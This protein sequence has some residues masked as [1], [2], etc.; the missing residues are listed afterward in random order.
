MPDR[1]SAVSALPA[2]PKP[3]RC[4]D[5]AWRD[6]LRSASCWTIK[7]GSRCSRVSPRWAT[8]PL[9][10][11]CPGGGLET[12]EGYEQAARR[13]F[14]EETGIVAEE[15][16]PVVLERTVRFTWDGVEFDQT[17]HYFVVRTSVQEISSDRWTEEECQVIVEHRWWTVDELRNASEPVFPEELT[18]LVKS[19]SR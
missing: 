1:R 11:F 9:A 18:R 6:G 3:A 16:G 15:L 2:V 17:E 4:D 10:G 5:E 7:A 8:S 19:V 14:F 12:G 13:E